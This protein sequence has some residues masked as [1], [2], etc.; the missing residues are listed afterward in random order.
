MPRIEIQTFVNAERAI[1]F[2]LSRSIDLH[3]ISTEHTHEKAIAGRITGLIELHETVTWRA[4]HF[5]VYQQLTTKITAFD[6]PNYFAD[7][8]ISGAFKGFKHEHHFA[9]LNQGTLMTDYFDYVSPLGVLGKL[10]DA[11]FLKNYME[12]LLERRN[13]IIKDFAESRDWR[14]LLNPD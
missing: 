9:D 10:A 13:Q 2:D 5:G 1:V 3:Q 4:K 14:K 11:L 8:M 6:Y 12:N 7:E